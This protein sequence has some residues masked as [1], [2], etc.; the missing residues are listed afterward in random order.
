MT[1]GCEAEPFILR[2]RRIESINLPRQSHGSSKQPPPPPPPPP[3][4]LLLL[5]LGCWVLAKEI[6]W[7]GSNPGSSSGIFL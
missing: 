2:R 6:V 3:L 5:L 4:L 7:L 1:C